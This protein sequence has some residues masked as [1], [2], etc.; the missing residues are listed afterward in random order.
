MNTKTQI[1]GKMFRNVETNYYLC[2]K[3]KVYG[4]GIFQV[5][6]IG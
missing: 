6:V 5:I 4:R 3:F 2:T 1:I